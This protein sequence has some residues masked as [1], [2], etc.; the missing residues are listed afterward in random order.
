MIY[1]YHTNAKKKFNTV[2][3]LKTEDSK[4][5]QKQL[6]VLPLQ[7]LKQKVNQISKTQ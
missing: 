3:Q 5:L 4:F 1:E 7:K 2:E 6:Y